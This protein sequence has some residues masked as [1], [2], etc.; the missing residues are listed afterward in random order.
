MSKIVRV[1]LI[2]ASNVKDA[3]Y[4]DHVIKKAMI[5][6]H[7]KLIKKA[8]D[9]KT[10]VLQHHITNLALLSTNE[11]DRLALRDGQSRAGGLAGLPHGTSFA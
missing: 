2:Q 4:P 1:G 11:S 3:S 6:K 8:A 5:D 9:K 7:L 10:Q